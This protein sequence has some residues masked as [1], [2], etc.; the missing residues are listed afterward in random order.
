MSDR[1]AEAV[2]GG[3]EE[4]KGETSSEIAGEA[5]EVTVTAADIPGAELAEPLDR[6]P[7]AAL[8]WWLLC[9]GA[10]VPTSMKKKELIDR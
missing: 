8:R 6:H 1:E 2:A 5:E 3:R 7:M 4:S 9:W 10:K